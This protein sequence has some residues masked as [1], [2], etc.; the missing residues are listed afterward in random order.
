MDKKGSLSK[1]QVTHHRESI[2]TSTH[3]NRLGK[4]ALGDLEMTDAQRDSSKFLIERTIG[5][6]SQVDVNANV[7][8]ELNI[9]VGSFIAPTDG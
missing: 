1:R 4:H 6:A 9:T 2:A 3:L 8:G 7:E 5:R